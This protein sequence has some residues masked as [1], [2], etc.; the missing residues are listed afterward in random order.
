MDVFIHIPKTGGSTIRFIVA[1]QYGTEHIIYFEPGGMVGPVTAELPWDPTIPSKNQLDK[2]LA[3]LDIKLIIGHQK[4]GVHHLMNMPCRYFSMVRDPIDRVISNY[5]YAFDYPE[6]T[7]GDQIRSGA[8]SL[9]DYISDPKICGREEQLG[10]LAGI[11]ESPRGGTDAA[12]ANVESCIAAVGVTERFD[13]SLLQIAKTFG[14]QPPLYVMRNVTK[15]EAELVEQRAQL[16]RELY[17]AFSEAFAEEYKLYDFIDRRVIERYL[18]EGVMFDRALNA[19]KELL[20][21]IA[22]HYADRKFEPFVFNDGSSIEL[23][24]RYSGSERYREIS[25]YLQ[26]PPYAKSQTRNYIGFV[27]SIDSNRIVGWATDRYATGPLTVTVRSNDKRVATAR[28]TIARDEIVRAGLATGPCG[29]DI[30]LD[31][32][33]SDLSAYKVCFEDSKVELL[34]DQQIMNYLGLKIQH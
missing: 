2:V 15:L 7:Y 6:H 24:E 18:T 32:G 3:G 19:Y 20:K 4:F 25:D 34:Q 28:C 11:F 8:L 23:S 30:K 10:H 27:E 12:I 17:T 14:W 21:D 33:V 1:Q 31:A 22:S 13:E 5:Y 29:F 26:S 9:E 16:R